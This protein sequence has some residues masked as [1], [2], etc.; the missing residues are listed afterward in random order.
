MQRKEENRAVRR[1]AEPEARDSAS[2][3]GLKS[4][5]HIQRFP[6]LLVALHKAEHSSFQR[7]CLIGKGAGLWS[8]ELHFTAEQT[9]GGREDFPHTLSKVSRVAHSLTSLPGCLGRIP[10]AGSCSDR[11]KI[12]S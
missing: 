12:S 4:L 9:A 7:Q 6:S 10:A 2:V 11:M 5:L 3:E 8:T 1:E